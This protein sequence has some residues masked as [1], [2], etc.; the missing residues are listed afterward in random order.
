MAYHVGYNPDAGKLF[1]G[2]I[3]KKG[4]KWVNKSE[5][6]EET[7][8]AVRDFFY[9]LKS[10]QEDNPPVV[11]YRWNFDNGMKIVLQLVVEEGPKE[12][13]SD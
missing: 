11:G 4:D 2:T 12:E 9:D 10:K 1:A 5:V 6:T 13:G 7:L 8:A 3:N